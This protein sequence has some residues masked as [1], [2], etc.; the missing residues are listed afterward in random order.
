VKFIF[1]D[2]RWCR[3]GCRG[4]WHSGPVPDQVL[5]AEIGHQC[6]QHGFAS[7]SRTNFDIFI[8]SIV[9]HCHILFQIIVA[10]PA[11]GPKPRKP[12]G[13]DADDE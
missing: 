1:L 13:M 8:Y 12:Q 9:M 2:R 5:G 11:G 10:K 6:G 7:G 3:E 4:S